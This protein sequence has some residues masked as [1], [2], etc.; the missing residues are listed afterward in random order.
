MSDDHKPVDFGWGAEIR[1]L[2]DELAALKARCERYEKALERIVDTQKY[3]LT[4]LRGIA[5][6]AL[7]PSRGGGK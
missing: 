1:R 6:A 7:A 5:R 4:D 2:K 3:N